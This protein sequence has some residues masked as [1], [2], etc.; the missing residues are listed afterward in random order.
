MKLEILKEKKL[1]FDL[2]REYLIAIRINSHQILIK[3]MKE[4]FQD[5][6]K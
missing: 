6:T 2:L 5:E 1:V 4:I 3:Y